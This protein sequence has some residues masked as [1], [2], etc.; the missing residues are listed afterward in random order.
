MRAELGRHSQGGRRRIAHR[1]PRESTNARQPRSTREPSMTSLDDF[2]AARRRPRLHAR[3]R[4]P[5]EARRLHA[6]HAPRRPWVPRNQQATFREKPTPVAENTP[7]AV[8][9][10]ASKQAPRLT[11]GTFG[12]P[13][14][15]ASQSSSVSASPGNPPCR[16]SSTPPV[17]TTSPTDSKL[18]ARES[19]SDGTA[20]PPPR[21]PA[22][23]T[24]LLPPA[25][26]PALPS[27][28][29][30]RALSTRGF[31]GKKFAI[32]A[33]CIASPDSVPPP[34][35][36]LPRRSS[37]TDQSESLPG[38][39]SPGGL[40]ESSRR[41]NDPLPDEPARPAPAKLPLAQEDVA[42]TAPPPR[43]RRIRPR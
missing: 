39:S 16:S 11:R 35:P 41:A 20:A 12:V 30:P 27:C 3:P 33:S 42:I 7:S 15:D 9:D 1:L 8:Q 29:V 18:L 14:C 43:G 36:G 22:S 2:A 26:L 40:M 32:T 10:S 31:A 5:R 28:F 17:T 21:A 25:S 13:G 6:K 23:A 37:R 4:I 34:S 38:S 24:P 19:R